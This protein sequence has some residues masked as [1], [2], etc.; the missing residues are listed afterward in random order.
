VF[1]ASLP[2]IHAC[3][4]TLPGSEISGGSDPTPAV[5]KEQWGK[6]YSELSLGVP[7]IS[8]RL[9]KFSTKN[10]NSSGRRFRF[11]GENFHSVKFGKICCN[12]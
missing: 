11:K 6:I 2:H 7:C 10:G 12:E 1:G 8:Y 4:R 3:K 9:V 5:I